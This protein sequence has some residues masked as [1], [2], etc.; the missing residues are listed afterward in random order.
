MH[1]KKVFLVLAAAI[2]SLTAYSQTV[3]QME[4]DGGVYKIPC[5]VN[6]LKL[7]F[8]FD[9]GASAVSISNT[10]A[11]MMLENDYLSRSDIKGSGTSQ[12]ANGQIVDHT[13]INLKEIE[14]AGLILKDVE[15]VVI[16]E[17]SAPLLLG[18][19]VIQRLG[20]VTI[21]GSKL[22]IEKQESGNPYASN[23]D[24]YSSEEYDRIYQEALSLYYDDHVVL[25]VEKFDIVNQAGRIPFI[26]TE[27]YAN[28]LEASEVGRYDDALDIMLKNEG[29]VKMLCPNKMSSYY[30]TIC[31]LAYFTGN[32]NQSIRYGELCQSISEFPMSQYTWTIYWISQSYLKLNNDYKSHQVI[33]DF[34]SRYMTFMNISATDCWTKNYKD[35]IV[36]EQ[37]YNLAYTYREYSDAKKYLIIS[38]AWGYKNAIEDCNK[39]ELS[40]NKI[41]NG[42]VY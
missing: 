40:Y 9:T 42:Y 32:Y 27:I 31:R 4:E 34:I 38:A 14:I 2:L 37:Y 10:V 41:P 17:Q 13:R 11:N 28:C 39:Y 29:V 23:P 35:P 36:A 16:H 8:I 19:S 20:K 7:K 1:H 5:K 25:A 24:S 26:D 30:G 6:G 12:I 15:A 3:I 22:I 18:Q 33:L 21:N